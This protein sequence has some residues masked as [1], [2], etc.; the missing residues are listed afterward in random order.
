MSKVLKNLTNPQ[1]SIWL[2]NKFYDSSSLFNLG[3]TL[4]IHQEVDFDKLDQAINLFI[5]KND[6]MRLAF[7]LKDGIT[8][9]YVQEYTYKKMP[10]YNV[11]SKEELSTLED[12][13]I[14][15]KFNISKSFLYEFKLIKLKNGHGGFNITLHHLISDAWSMSLLVSEI[16][17]IYSKLVKGDV[18]SEDSK[19]SYLDYIQTEQKYLNSEKFN[20][21]TLFWEGV[22]NKCPSCVS[23]SQKSPKNSSQSAKRKIFDLENSEK[24]VEFCKNNNTSVFTFLMSIFALYLHRITGTEDIIIGSPILNRNGNIEKNMIGLFINTLPIKIEIPNKD[25]PFS[26]LVQ[27]VSDKQFSIFR[28]HKYPYSKILEFVRKKYKFNN[29]LYDTI[30]SYQNARNNSKTSDIE[31]STNWDFNGSTFNSLDVHIYDMDNTGILKLFYDYKVDLFDEDEINDIHNRILHIIEQVINNYEISINNIDIVTEKEKN[32][33]LYTFNNTK[34]DYPKDKTINELFEEQCSKTPDKTAIIFGDS[35]LTYKE[36]NEKANQLAYF[37]RNNKGI[38]SNSFVGV[39]TKRSL[40]MAIGILGIL[41]AGA[42]Y[43]PIDPEYPE[44]RISYMLE[45][46]GAKIILVDNYTKD[47]YKSADII[48]IDLK[49]EIYN[50][51]PTTNLIPI[52]NPSDLMYLIYTSGSTGKPKG[53]MLMHKNVNNYLHGLTE[54]IDFS[55]NKTIISVTTI[56]FDIFVTEFWGGLLN[57]LTVVIAN[58]QEQNIASD[59][60]KLCLKHNVNM[61]QTTPSRFNALLEDDSSFLNN[62]TDLMVGGEALPKKLLNKLNSFS[63]I[64]VFNMYGPTETAVWSTIK[65]SPCEENI[66]IGKPIANTQIYILDDNNNLLPPNIPGNLFIGGDGVCKGYYNR[67]DLNEKV[68]IKSPFDNSTLYNTKDLAYIQ[69]DGEIVHLGRSDFQ[70]KVHGFRVELGEI[71]NTIMNYSGISNVVVLLQDGSLNAYIVSGQ[72]INTQDLLNYLMKALPHY[73]LP[74]TITQIP[75]MPLTPNGKIDRKNEIFKVSHQ[76]S[77]DKVEPRNENE[78]LLYDVIKKTLGLDIGVTDNIFEFGVDSLM[79]IKLVSKLYLYSI[80]LS[81]QDFYDHPSIEAIAKK[82]SCNLKPDFNTINNTNHIQDVSKLVKKIPY[83][84]DIYPKDVLLT[85][86]TGFLGIHVLESLISNSNCNIYCLIRSKDEKSPTTRLIERLNY[87]FE[88]KFI[89]LINKRIFIIDSDITSPY[90]GLSKDYYNKLGMKIS[91]VIHCAADVRH[92]GN[93]NISEKVNI[94]ATDN[95]IK[96]CLDFHVVLNHISTM[97]VSGYGLVNVNY[98]GIFDE[99]KFYIHQNYEDN[100]YVKTKFLA[101]EE[102]FKSSNESG[103]V[104]NIYRIGNLTNR[105]SDYKFQYNS[106][107]NG[108]LNKLKSIKNLGVLPISMKDYQLELT[109]VDLCADAI[110]KLAINKKIEN[111]INI[112]HLYNNNYISMNVITNILNQN[113]INIKYLNKADF[114]NTIA[115][116]YANST[117]TP[118]FVDNLNSSQIPDSY[119]KI[120]SSSRTLKDLAN[121]NFSWPQITKDYLNYIIRRI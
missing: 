73:M 117:G 78:Q 109:P 12:I 71:E 63:W 23:F 54:K 9:Q 49:S 114:E 113:N 76:V 101:E 112:Y 102:I 39:L 51:Y 96:F 60:S 87:Y 97:T 44:E 5:K 15:T 69:K 90:F 75:V 36:L 68:F 2:S 11:N 10:I 107:E 45:D 119:D 89:N 17:D 42:T 79:V 28:H 100:I 3:G 26:Q 31:Y 59:L 67:P 85:G 105:L 94:K 56:C 43:V 104:A 4:L 88:D 74:K 120:F 27:Q 81:I 38:T 34:L 106:Y 84:I 20:K 95:I 8:Y 72:K 103:L 7:E 22:F 33:L 62:I 99:N 61:I 46:S 29:S 48:N 55:D 52:N 41:K 83:D 82:I 24:I 6:G 118:G 18:L 21:D 86:V 16:I 50:T 13:F 25:I 35:S 116:N 66:T 58:E 1:K 80:N 77:K 32:D 110:V 108:F 115:S 70:A 92:Y 37:L 47:I 57:G 65:E 19:P 40:E 53:V 111:N 64:K 30:I 121:L 93:Y 91:S 14:H 98:D